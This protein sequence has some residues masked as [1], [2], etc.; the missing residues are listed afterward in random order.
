M[1]QFIIFTFLIFYCLEEMDITESI[2]STV[3]VDNLIHLVGD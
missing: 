2:V 3:I 1:T